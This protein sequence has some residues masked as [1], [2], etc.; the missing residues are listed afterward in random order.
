MALKIKASARSAAP[1]VPDRFRPV[2]AAVSA[3]DPFV[4]TPVPVHDAG[5]VLAPPAAV[6]VPAAG[7]VPDAVPDAVPVQKSVHAPSASGSVPVPCSAADSVT[8]RP[9]FQDFIVQVAVPGF[10]RPFYVSKYYRGRYSLT[11]D[12]LYAKTWSSPVLALQHAARVREKLV[13]YPSSFG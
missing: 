4:S 13:D 12:P 2:Y 7:S 10:S 8:V 11:R 5:S 9:W 1:S 6:S 3:P